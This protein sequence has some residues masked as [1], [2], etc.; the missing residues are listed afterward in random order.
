VKVVVGW[1]TVETVEVDVLGALV[2]MVVKDCSVVV[3]VVTV[4]AVEVVTVG[5]LVVTTVS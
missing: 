4:A 2:V 3:N 1:V 5:I